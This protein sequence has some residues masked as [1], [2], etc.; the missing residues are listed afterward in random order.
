MAMNIGGGYPMM[1]GMTGMGMGMGTGGTQN[2]PK[3][4][5]AKYGCEDCFR[6][7]PY[8]KEFPKP[9]TPEPNLNPSWFKRF[10]NNILGG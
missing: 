2:I 5:E 6:K 10:S 3:Y 1:N 9:V 8:W 7:E 4:F